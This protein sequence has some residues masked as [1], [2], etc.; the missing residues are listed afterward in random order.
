MPP[1]HEWI[2]GNARRSIQ[3]IYVAGV[4][5]TL[6]TS[7]TVTVSFP[8]AFST[9]NFGASCTSGMVGAGNG[10]QSCTASTTTSTINNGTD[11]GASVHWM[12]SGY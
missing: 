11:A 5:S 3:E 8:I 1:I 12:A 2:H 10:T 4:T 7:R 6:I 9:N